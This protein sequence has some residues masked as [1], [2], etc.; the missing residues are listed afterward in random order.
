MNHYTAVKNYR[1]VLVWM[2]LKTMFSTKSK[3]LKNMYSEILLT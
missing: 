1:Y 2:K 3:S